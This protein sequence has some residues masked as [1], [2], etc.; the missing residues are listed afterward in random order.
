ME[1]LLL[2]ELAATLVIL[3]L[4]FKSIKKRRKKN[5]EK[6]IKQF[7]MCKVLF[8]WIPIAGPIALWVFGKI[9]KLDE[10]YDYMDGVGKMHEKSMMAFT[11]MID[12]R[13][14][15]DR[16]QEIRDELRYAGLKNDD[17]VVS[18]DGNIV[19]IDGVKHNREKVLRNLRNRG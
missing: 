5:P 12:E 1:V 16:E 13:V 4:V 18:E 8:G 6:L 19:T 17:V 7:E 2:I 15:Y 9:F 14:K 10:M 11:D 3:V